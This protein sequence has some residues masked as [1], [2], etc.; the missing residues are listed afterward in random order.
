[1]SGRSGFGEN[2]WAK[3]VAFAFLRL[4]P[5]ELYQSSQNPLVILQS[6][7]HPPHAHTCRAGQRLPLPPLSSGLDQGPVAGPPLVQG[8]PWPRRTPPEQA[9]TERHRPGSASRS[10]A[11]AATARLDIGTS[12]MRIRIKTWASALALAPTWRH[13]PRSGLR[14]PPA[15]PAPARGRGG[16]GSHL[17]SE[18]LMTPSSLG[19]ITAMF[20]T[21]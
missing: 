16:S 7:E 9:P 18:T 6:S 3:G 14:G 8:P 1:M 10:H 12:R 17:S 19:T 15:R 2:V 11:A 13:S 21:S 5:S 4:E 20:T